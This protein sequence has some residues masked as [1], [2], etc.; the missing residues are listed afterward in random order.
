M[1]AM[2][3]LPVAAGP[4]AA[5]TAAVAIPCAMRKSGLTVFRLA[6]LSAAPAAAGTAAAVCNASQLPPP[7]DG[8]WA[9]WAETALIIAVAVAVATAGQFAPSPFAARLRAIIT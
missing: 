6:T 2:T 3:V 7:V 4:V 5:F 1:A 8:A 9:T